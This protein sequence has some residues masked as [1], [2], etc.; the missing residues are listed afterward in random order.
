MSK[1]GWS[2]GK[3]RKMLDIVDLEV[4]KIA[5]DAKYNNSF[6]IHDIRSWEAGA[7]D[8]IS[9]LRQI[10]ANSEEALNDD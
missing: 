9:A 1:I 6:Q 8:A 7:T 2:A 3:I 10:L 5:G 4:R